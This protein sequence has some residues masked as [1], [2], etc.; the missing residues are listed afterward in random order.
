MVGC[1]KPNESDF[2]ETNSMRKFTHA[3][4][5][6]LIY[7]ILLIAFAAIGISAQDKTATADEMFRAQLIPR[8]SKV[9]IA[10]FRS[11]AAQEGTTPAGF[12]SYM[13]AALRKKKVPLLIVS[14]PHDADFAIEGT[15]DKKGAGWA[16]KIFFGDLRSSVSASMTVTNTKTNVVVYADSSDRSSANRG[17]RSSA[18]KLAKYLKKK[19]E[20]DEKKLGKMP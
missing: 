14:D 10:P 15:A 3:R 16:K 17:Y 7:T 5:T 18:E 9:Y 1:H 20:N 4:S 19:I 13:A 11:E 6:R 2:Q 8:G 12:E